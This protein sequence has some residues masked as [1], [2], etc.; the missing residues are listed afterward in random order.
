ML[1]QHDISNRY[2]FSKMKSEWNQRIRDFLSEATGLKLNKRQTAARAS[3]EVNVSVQIVSDNRDFFL[4]KIISHYPDL[5]FNEYES[6]RLL[7]K[8]LDNSSTY[9]ENDANFLQIRESCSQ[10]LKRYDINDLI[11][12]LFNERTESGEV[13]GSYYLNTHRVEIYYLPLLVLSKI[14]DISLEHSFVLVLVHELAHAYHHL[15]KDTDGNHWKWMRNADLPIIEG[16]AQYYTQLFVNYYKSSIPEFERTFDQ[17]LKV[18]PPVYSCHLGWLD[19]KKESVATALKLLRINDIE[20]FDEFDRGLS[21]LNE[22]FGG[23]NLF[24]T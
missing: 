1:N 3:S 2:M 14:K 11:K 22:M 17:M 19:Y 8:A 9:F 16:L 4:N 13:W 21:G 18:L 24:V 10:Y 6:K 7:L 15:G 20:S 23:H 12:R 5:D